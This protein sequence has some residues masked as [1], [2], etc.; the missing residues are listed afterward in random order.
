MKQSNQEKYND[1]ELIYLIK[2]HHDEAY[3]ILQKKY[4]PIIVN[5]SKIINRIYPNIGLEIE[6]YIIEGKLALDK[7]INNFNDKY[8]NLFYTYA[9]KYLKCSLL[10]FVKKNKKD[11]NLNSAVEWIDELKV[12]WNTSN[13]NKLEI[14]E[15]IEN[16]FK[17]LK[18]IEKQIFILKLKG[19]SYIQIAGIL[20]IGKKKVDNT[21][22][23]IRRILK[24]GKE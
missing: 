2:E 11:Y 14:T 10:T 21:L 19:Y 8:D 23:K 16:I 3:Q 12:D 7:A 5:L 22:L 17:Y 24:T 6:D 15:S 1:F 18:P 9:V 20:K 13:I 4:E